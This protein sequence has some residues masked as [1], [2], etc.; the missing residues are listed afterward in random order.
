M[1]PIYVL[2]DNDLQALK[3]ALSDPNRPAHT[4][5]VAFDDGGVKF[6]INQGMWSPPMGTKDP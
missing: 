2:S 1:D 4:L 3:N 5:R 6:K